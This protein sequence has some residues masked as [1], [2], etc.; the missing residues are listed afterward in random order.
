LFFGDFI[1]LSGTTVKLAQS[2]TCRPAFTSPEAN[3]TAVYNI[4][5]T[6]RKATSVAPS[7]TVG[8][9]QRSSKTAGETMQ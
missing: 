1:V 9:T 6:L 3:R 8:R 2:E 4:I 5:L 7:V